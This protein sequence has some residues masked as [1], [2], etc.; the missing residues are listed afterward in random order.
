MRVC[1]A[2]QTINGD[3]DVRC[4]DCGVDISAQ[5][6]LSPAMALPRPLPDVLARRNRNYLWLLIL[7]PLVVIGNLTFW[8]GVVPS[9][10]R[11]AVD[12]RETT[13]Q[14]NQQAIEQALAACKR[15]TGGVP[16]RLSVLQYVGVAKSDLT[17]GA[18]ARTWRGPYLPAARPF[19]ANPYRPRAGA[20]GWRYRMHGNDG[21]VS[22]AHQT[23]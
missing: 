21:T 23:P 3:S 5:Y 1:R 19:P 16:T 7:L 6:R 8:C 11:E 10:Q 12:A 13:L 14:H 17:P 4:R 20:A 22:P 18:D 2:C 9:L 15:D